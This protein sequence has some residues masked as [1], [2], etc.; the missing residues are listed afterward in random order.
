MI[1][2]LSPISDGFFWNQTWC[3]CN[4]AR[5]GTLFFFSI[6]Q[7]WSITPSYRKVSYNLPP[8][9]FLSHQFHF[10]FFFK[11]YKI[12]S[13]NLLLQ[14]LTSYTTTLYQFQYCKAKHRYALIGTV[15]LLFLSLHYVGIWYH[16]SLVPQRPG[17][18]TLMYQ[19]CLIKVK[20][21]SSYLLF[22]C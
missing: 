17:I 10:P 3:S 21:L 8:R 20:V 12:T 13:S 2:S 6:F 4:V 22:F 7:A 14:V 19:Y 5:I 15:Q 18:V 1:K 16:I 9:S 11:Q